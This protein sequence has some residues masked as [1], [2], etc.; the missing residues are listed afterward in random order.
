MV[1]IIGQPDRVPEYPPELLPEGSESLTWALVPNRVLE[2]SHVVDEAAL[3][4]PADVVPGRPGVADHNSSVVSEDPLGNI[5]PPGSVH[6]VYH[7]PPAQEG[8]EP[9]VPALDAP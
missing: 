3:P 8:P 6:L 7:A 4:A 5:L 9:V 2:L 1:I